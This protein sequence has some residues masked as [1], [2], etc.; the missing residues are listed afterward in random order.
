MLPNS[1]LIYL[2]HEPD[3]DSP[4]RAD[5]H[6]SSL[7][8]ETFSFSVDGSISHKASYA[9]FCSVMGMIEQGYDDLVF[10]VR[11]AS[12]SGI[13][14]SEITADSMFIP[15]MYRHFIYSGMFGETNRSSGLGSGL[16]SIS[17][18]RRL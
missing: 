1:L 7:P 6:C 11:T 9:V 18:T 2:S 3:P 17:H 5:C 12:Y 4:S 8:K 10:C 15:L 16:P 13:F 14:P